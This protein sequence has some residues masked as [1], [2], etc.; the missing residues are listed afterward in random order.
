MQ[1]YL[2]P[3]LEATLSQNLHIQGAAFDVLNHIVRQ[4]LA[5]PLQVCHI[6]FTLCLVL[7]EY[8]CVVF[9]NYRC[10]GDQHESDS[11]WEGK[12]FTR[13]AAQ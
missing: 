4:G 11:E 6:Y 13:N 3:I 1:R 2:N 12:Q 8:P 5:H 9:P 7:I 10:F